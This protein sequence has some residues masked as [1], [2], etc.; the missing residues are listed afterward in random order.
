M[1]K[2]MVAARLA[3]R[4]SLVRW[5]AP[6]LLLASFVQAAEPPTYSRCPGIGRP[7]HVA[8]DGS[9]RK[10]RSPQ[11]LAVAALQYCDIVAWGR[12]V[13]VC[14]ENYHRTTG[15]SNAKVTVKFAVDDT[16]FGEPH[17]FI[18]TRMSRLML[19]WPDTNLSWDAHQS[20]SNRGRILREEA[21]AKGQDLLKDIF[22]AG[23]PLT[24]DHYERLSRLLAQAASGQLSMPP[25][26]IAIMLSKQTF[27]SA[28]G[29]D[30]VL[31]LGA[32]TPERSFLAGFSKPG[33]S[34]DDFNE[35][36]TMLYWGQ[37]ALDV[38]EQIRM[39]SSQGADP[40][41]EEES[42]SRNQ[43]SESNGR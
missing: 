43:T 34:G 27:S 37:E 4:S 42:P 11:E 31:E 13:S 35:L 18:R 3:V 1:V 22:E 21:A 24:G 30:F 36:S 15:M 19:V 32:V 9:I 7:G 17:E 23:A 14:D 26:E 40:S 8:V 12:F 10:E 25:E 6:L 39:L 16:L 41:P 38:A 2:H 33:Q 20:V 5:T 29:L 28:G